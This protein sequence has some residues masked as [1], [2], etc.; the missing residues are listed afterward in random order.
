MKQRLF[1][2]IKTGA[3]LLAA[4]CA[5][6][7]FVMKT[8]I[9]IPCLFRTVTGLKC[10]GCGVS[11]MLLSL[12]KFDLKGAWQSNPVILIMLPLL[13]YLLAANVYR[14]VR[15]GTGKEPKHETVIEIIMIIVLVAFGIFRNV[16]HFF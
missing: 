8:G 7:V 12:L 4:G 9:F 6:A 5:Y 1:K 10:P 3:V 15:Y 11:H 16:I 2:V 14:Y 13:L